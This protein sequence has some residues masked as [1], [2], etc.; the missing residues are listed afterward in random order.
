MRG[1]T[2][3]SVKRHSVVNVTNILSNLY[4]ELKV[5]NQHIKYNYTCTHPKDYL[6]PKLNHAESRLPILLGYLMSIL[7]VKEYHSSK[8]IH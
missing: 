3:F 2:I 6:V 5:Y 1:P 8:W 7:W 4:L